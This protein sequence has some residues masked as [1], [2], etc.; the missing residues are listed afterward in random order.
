MRALVADVDAAVCVHR[1]LRRL[2]EPICDHDLDF[3]RV[4]PVVGHVGD[5]RRIGLRSAVMREPFGTGPAATGRQTAHPA[6]PLPFEVRPHEAEG[7]SHGRADQH[8]VGQARDGRRRRVILQPAAP[9][10]GRVPRRV[11]RRVE[12][13]L[14]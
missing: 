12:R 11:A 6:E 9:A 2:L 10:V 1:Q 13:H 5:D 3:E 7:F 4:V 8:L 14:V